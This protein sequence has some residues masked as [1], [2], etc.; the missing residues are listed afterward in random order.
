M[1]LNISDPLNESNNVGGKKTE[2]E[3]LREMFRITSFGLREA[4]GRDL[5]GYLFSLSNL[6]K[7]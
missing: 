6:L 3:R 2:T 7:E 5:L 4:E 1:R